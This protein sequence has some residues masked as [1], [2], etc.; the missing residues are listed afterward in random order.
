MRLFPGDRTR[1]PGGPNGSGHDETPFALPDG[2]DW[3][4]RTLLR[5]PHGQ[6]VELDGECPEGCVSPIKRMGMV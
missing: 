4:G 3:E 5:C 6:R 2:W 1:G